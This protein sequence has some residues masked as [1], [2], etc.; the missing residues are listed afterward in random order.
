MQ[1]CLQRSAVQKFK[2]LESSLELKE[3]DDYIDELKTI[4]QKLGL[5]KTEFI[6]LGGSS[7]DYAG[8]R[9]HRD[10][11]I[12]VLPSK[13][14]K[15]LIELLGEQKTRESK[16]NTVKISENVEINKGNVFEEWGISDESLINNGEYSHVDNELK[17]VRLEMMYSKKMYRC[18][19]FKKFRFKD[20]YD[21]FLINRAKDSL[22]FW[23][24]ELILYPMTN[25]EKKK[26]KKIV[27]VSKIY[28]KTIEAI[29][30]MKNKIVSK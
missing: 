6:L 30:Q 5:D 14:E 22:K 26:A 7:L 1:D 3:M 20:L 21:V 11:D 23:N 27:L 8:I 16:G 28:G 10:I 9:K 13:K 4:T 18:A 24:D 12:C 15:V 25:L 2:Y 19:E 29:K 17:I